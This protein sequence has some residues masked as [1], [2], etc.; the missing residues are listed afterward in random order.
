MEILK[1][2][3]NQKKKKNPEL[4]G[5]T[6]PDLKLYYKAIIIKTTW[7][8]HK[9]KHVDQGNRIEDSEINP[10]VKANSQQRH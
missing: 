10:S 2:I 7:Y 8:R 4:K 1:F 6:I 9:N 5:N 3:W